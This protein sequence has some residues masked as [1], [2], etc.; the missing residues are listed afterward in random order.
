M[1]TENLNIFINSDEFASEAT[2]GSSSFKGILDREPAEVNGVEGYYPTL[3]CISSETTTINVG[4]V[5][6]IAGQS[7]T[8]AAKRQDGTG[9][10]K[11][12]L[13]YML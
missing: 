4:A 5:I 1:F 10:V 3:T 9:L 11:M 12:L 7:Y 13:E 8:I 2:A 6:S